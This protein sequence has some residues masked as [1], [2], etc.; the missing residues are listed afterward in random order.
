[1]NNERILSH[2]FSKKLSIEEI[3]NISAAG[4]SVATANVTYSTGGGTDVNA[5][6]NVDM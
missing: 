5:D 2:Q 4:T 1:M 3:E 6:A